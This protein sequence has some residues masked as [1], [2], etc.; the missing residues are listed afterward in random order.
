MGRHLEFATFCNVFWG[1]GGIEQDF[2]C[3]FSPEHNVPAKGDRPLTF[4]FRLA[5]FV[6]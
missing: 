6:T 3:R 1:G 4:L 5:V 2:P